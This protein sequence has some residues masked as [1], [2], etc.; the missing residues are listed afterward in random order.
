MI[1][2]NSAQGAEEE[3]QQP[4]EVLMFTWNSRGKGLCALTAAM[5]IVLVGCAN[6]YV[7]VIA[8]DTSKSYP[9][10]SLAYALEY[11][12]T[13]H[14][15]YRDKV[16]ELGDAERTLSNGLIT[17]GGVLVGLAASKAHSSATGGVAI[18]GGLG[19][20]LGV[21]NTDKRRSL[22]YVAG[23]KALECAN[24][25]VTPLN[26]GAQA[27]S[28]LQSQMSDVKESSSALSKRIGAVEAD[29]IIVSQRV[30]KAESSI[31]SA[32][33]AVNATQEILARASQ[34]H[35]AGN[36]LLAKHG[37]A[38]E[39]LRNAVQKIDAAVLDELRGTEAAIQSVPSI[40][41]DLAV[42]TKVFSDLARPPAAPASGAAAEDAPH[43]K[44]VRS[45]EARIRRDKEQLDL[46]TALATSVAALKS[47][48]SLLES[49]SQRLSGIVASIQKDARGD[50]LKTCKVEGV[51]TTMT[52]T[53][54]TLTFDEK[55]ANTQ[56][57]LVKGGKQNY[58]AQFAQSAHPGLSIEAASPFLRS[59]VIAV[60][61]TK[62]ATANAAGYQIVVRDSSNQVQIVMV[63]V[64]P[65][66]GGNAGAGESA[67][68]DDLVS[69]IMSLSPV[70]VASGTSVDINKVTIRPDGSPEVTYKPQAGKTVKGDEVAA[71]LMA[72]TELPNL[73]GT[74]RKIVAV[75]EGTEAPHGK[76]VPATASV[77]FG[78]AV[79]TLKPPDVTTI[80]KNLC[81]KAADIDGAWGVRTQAAL[82]KD[83][84]R[85]E[86]AGE[87]GVPQG[88][89]QGA[90]ARAL[91][92]RTAEQ[93]GKMCKG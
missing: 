45:V 22:I 75:A 55:T 82:I 13:Y 68:N 66:S 12:R 70:K 30:P 11:S 71:A 25:A 35:V 43:G 5:S 4:T 93:T 32:R 37:L 44:V 86:M 7:R 61:A 38:G 73:L 17:L 51:E 56:M 85:R 2:A 67:S 39:H 15:A 33:Q 26:L 87:K 80:Q 72:D 19:Y 88:F 48:T 29:I 78:S 79:A 3:R 57:L 9:P 20:T 62:D 14:D 47:E 6:P 23:M 24:D 49:R 59:D 65:K 41:A 52:V 53:P 74:S 16:I 90:E 10:A 46:L 21:F 60:T 28:D 8:P 34:A 40:I 64:G 58:S 83:R 76:K 91:L 63:K 36:E 69:Y 84:D 54:Q 81:M 89:L 77:K 1:R 50:R 18:L 27:L 31:Q 42:N 92:E